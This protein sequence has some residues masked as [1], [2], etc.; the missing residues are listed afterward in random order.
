M[1]TR[2]QVRQQLVTLLDADSTF[3]LVYGYAPTDL[4][5]A[6]KVL[7]VYTDTTRHEFISA[8]LNNNFYDF[9]LET[10]VKRTGAEADENNLDDMH[11]AVR[12]VI[13]AN[14]VNS[15][16]NELNLDE[17]SDALFAEVSGIQYRVERHS[18]IVKVSTN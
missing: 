16:W 8:G 10:Y 13:R 3:N 17:D 18:L 2:K 12:T 6:T 7:C 14:I 4:S 1:G 11:E 5:G 15:N 9:I